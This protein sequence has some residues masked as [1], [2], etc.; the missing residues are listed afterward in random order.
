MGGI[1]ESEILLS[2]LLKEVLA[3]LRQG[4]T[5]DFAQG[6]YY[7][8]VALSNPPDQILQSPRRVTKVK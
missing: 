6:T 1:D 7:N 2:E 8:A 3:L 4:K 5:S